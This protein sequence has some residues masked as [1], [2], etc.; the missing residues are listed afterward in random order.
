[1]S[2]KPPDVRNRGESGSFNLNLQHVAR[3][4]V[5]IVNR[6]SLDA[7]VRCGDFK[8]GVSAHVRAP[9]TEMR[10]VHV[11]ACCNRLDCQAKIGCFAIAKRGHSR[12]ASMTREIKQKNVKPVL[13]QRRDQ[14]EHVGSLRAITVANHNRRSTRQARK[15]PPLMLARR[16][17]REKKTSKDGPSSRSD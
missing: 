13:L 3:I 11:V 1:M 15:K 8:R 14:C 10:R 12:A 5:S 9:Q 2:E 4:I 16:S 6:Q 17:H 7:L